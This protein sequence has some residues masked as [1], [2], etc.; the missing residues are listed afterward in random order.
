MRRRVTQEDIAA[1]T[2]MIGTRSPRGS[3]WVCD[4]YQIRDEEIVAEYAATTFIV[5]DGSDDMALHRHWAEYDPLEEAPD[6]FL[7]LASLYDEPD[8]SAAALNFCHT[9]GVPGGSSVEAG[10]RADRTNILSFLAESKR[11]RDIL[12]M[13]EATLN[14]DF[15]TM[16]SLL[17]ESAGRL[18][19]MGRAV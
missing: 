6:L 7:K 15:D 17:S 10:G 2:R 4:G 16:M 19:R 11:A 1:A 12:T 8:F 5:P 3:W 13:Y 18:E 14:K 9:Y